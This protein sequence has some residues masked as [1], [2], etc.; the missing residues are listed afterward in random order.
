MFY[1]QSNI[2]QS[3]FLTLLKYPFL[4]KGD[5]LLSCI[6][7]CEQYFLNFQIF[8][9]INENNWKNIQIAEH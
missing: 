7:Y 5:H 3:I 1:L 6:I 4:G 2:A 8:I 9:L